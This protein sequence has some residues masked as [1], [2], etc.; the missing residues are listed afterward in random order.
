MAITVQIIDEVDI[1]EVDTDEIDQI[2]TGCSAWTDR[3]DSS[4]E[5]PSMRSLAMFFAAVIA[6]VFVA[7]DK[8]KPMLEIKLRGPETV[9]AG[10]AIKGECWVINNTDSNM[11]VSGTAKMCGPGGCSTIPKPVLATIKPHD[12]A[13]FTRERKAPTTAGEYTVTVTAQTKGPDGKKIESKQER[14]LVVK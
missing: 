6:F 10:S 9:V 5:G 13:Y 12:F 3:Y 2:D 11:V 7:F 8:P 1:D 4:V 14:K